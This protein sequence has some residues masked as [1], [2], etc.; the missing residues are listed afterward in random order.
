MPTQQTAKKCKTI[1]VIISNEAKTLH[2]IGQMYTSDYFTKEQM[3]KYEILA[4]SDKVWEKY[5]THFTDLYTLRKA[6]DN[7]RAANS[8]FKSAAHV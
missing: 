8:N 7:N 3:T 4:D 1:N 2:F 6:Y 5:L